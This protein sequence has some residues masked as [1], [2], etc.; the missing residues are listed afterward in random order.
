M[1]ICLI[2]APCLGTDDV[3][4]EPPLGLLYIASNLRENGYKDVEIYTMTDATTEEEIKTKIDKIPF[5]NVYGFTV[6]CTNYNYVKKCIEHI[7]TKNP[8]SYIILGGPN[9]SGLPEFTL[10]DS[11]CDFV[12]IG[13]GEDAVFNIIDKLNYGL[14]PDID[15]RR[16]I[17][18]IVRED[19]NTLPFP[20]WDLVDLS[21]FSR[22]LNGE[23]VIS[24]ISS[25]GC[26]NKCVHCNSIIM[27]AGRK[28]R[29][30][31]VHNVIEEIK[32]LQSL[33]YNNF[34]FSDDNFTIRPD[35]YKFL[36]E[37]KTLNIKYRI[38]ARIEQLNDE[39]CKLLA[40]SG[41]QHIAIGLESLNPD[42][43]KFL[44]K[45]TN[46][47]IMD[48]NL[49]NVRRHGMMSRIY[50]IV[51]LPSDNDE[52]I[53]KYFFMASL[54]TFDEWTCYPLLPYPGTEIW[55]HPEQFGYSIIDRDSTLYY[56]ILKN[57][58]TC[59]VLDHKN[60]T[61]KDVERWLN[62]VND[63]LENRG[64]THTEESDTK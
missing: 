59:Y 15:G 64:K 21:K 18:G 1:K 37:L 48:I 61:H 40:E 3:N 57:K 63:L 58:K 41:C 46:V 23:R 22:V 42:N 36:R 10:K 32:Y 13:E 38:F 12:V 20:A 14:E 56:Q 60:F 9:A 27:G 8:S 30:R 50:F 39:T 44:R 51:G 7:R 19:I 34:R 5:A 2:N 24:I 45:N 55:E 52:T 31:T 26:P 4:L 25:R 47:E 33:G 53:E 29:Y 54:L 16:I 17:N 11:G 6:Y 49:R 35:L 28:I 43:L 62:Y